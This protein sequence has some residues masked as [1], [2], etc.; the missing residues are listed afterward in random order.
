MMNPPTDLRFALFVTLE[1]GGE[2]G[3]FVSMGDVLTCINATIGQGCCAAILMV[4]ARLAASAAK[5]A[6]RLGA[7]SERIDGRA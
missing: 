4:R 3:E 5:A 1:L 2:P 6:A 7:G